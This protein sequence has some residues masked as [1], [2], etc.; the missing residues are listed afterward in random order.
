MLKTLTDF[1]QTLGLPLCAEQ[2]QKLADYGALVWGKKDFLNLTS[3]ADLQEVCQRHLCD[4]L[5]AAAKVRA[6]AHIKGLE[7]FTLADA[8]AGAGYIGLTLAI[9]LPQ[10]EVTLI[11]SLEKRSSFMNWAI[12]Q[13]GLTN[14]KVKNV[15]LGQ[16]KTFAFDFI[17]ERAM[18]QLPDVLPLCVSALKTGGV[19]VAFQGEHPQ[20]KEAHPEK[21][22]AELLGVEHYTLPCDDKKRHLVLF[23]KKD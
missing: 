9:S 18:G 7:R 15:R 10:A 16:K 17:T 22:H 8:G 12:L 11:E 1:A 5:V 23:V 13:L 4:G 20:E 21:Y 3:A 19:F 6:M 2:A 14:A